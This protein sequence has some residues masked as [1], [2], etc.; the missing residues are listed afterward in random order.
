MNRLLLGMV[1]LVSVALGTAGVFLPL[2]PTVP[3]ILLAVF[4]FARSNSGLEAW[5]VHH[6]HFGPSI[7]AW[8]QSRSIGRQ[9][10]R[11]AW[12]AFM[13]SAALGVVLLQ[14]WWGLIPVSVAVL[15]SLWV[16]GLPTT[17][18]EATAQGRSYPAP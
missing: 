13:F 17:S 7:R 3:F 1:G 11:A 12:F 6:R 10:K 9:A 2:V 5:L 8:R 15:G 4:C 18:S 14:S 16:A